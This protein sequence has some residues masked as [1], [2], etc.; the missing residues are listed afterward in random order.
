MNKT[1]IR[2][3]VF[4]LI[5]SV[6]GYNL[7]SRSSQMAQSAAK[8]SIVYSPSQQEA[9]YKALQNSLYQEL[10]VA[11]R[12]QNIP[13]L[14]LLL[15]IIAEDARAKGEKA[16]DYNLCALNIEHSDHLFCKRHQNIARLKMPQ[17]QG[18]PIPGSP[19]DALPRNDRKEVDGNAAFLDY[20]QQKK[21][22]RV[23]LEDVPAMSLKATQN[24]LIG[25][26]VAGIW[27]AMQD[28]NSDTY[29]TITSL[30]LFISQEGYILDGHHRWAAA[31]AHAINN[32]DLTHMMMK[33]KR[34]HVPIS[35]LVQDAND[36][37]KEFGIQAEAGL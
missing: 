23:T 27:Y 8:N 9:L 19:A 20:L 2:Y 28:P 5:A 10:A 17:L 7:I 36:F 24:E 6:I 30:P 21:G 37:T 3:F 35:Q 18:T 29:K 12:N 31:I 26:K 4:V 13:T 25:S 15:K 14:L 33:A 11:E 22:Y 32:G 34:V 1:H 16:P